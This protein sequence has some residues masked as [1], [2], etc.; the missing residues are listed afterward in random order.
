[1]KHIDRHCNTCS[2]CSKTGQQL[3]RPIAY[4]SKSLNPAQQNYEVPEREALAVVLALEHFRPYVFG[5]HTEVR[6]DQRSL[7]WLFEQEFPAKYVRYRSRLAA[8]E[9]TIRHVPGLSNKA[10]DWLSR[11][12]IEIKESSEDIALVRAERPNPDFTVEVDKARNTLNS[13]CGFSGKVQMNTTML[14]GETQEF[15]RE[16]PF[17]QEFEMAVETNKLKFKFGKI[18]YMVSD[19]EFEDGM[20]FYRAF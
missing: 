7:Q 2:E 16:D 20:W 11:Y 4:F 19:F 9:Y 13:I 6:C 15:L 1:M 5:H 3:L 10:A 14:D 12:G 17:F 8:Y 18:S